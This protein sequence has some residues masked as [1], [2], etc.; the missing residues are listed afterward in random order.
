MRVS[1][2]QSPI[3]RIEGR[4]RVAVLAA[5]GESAGI[6]RRA[7]ITTMNQH[8]NNE[9]SRW[10]AKSDTTISHVCAVRQRN[11]SPCVSPA[12]KIWL[13][14]DDSARRTTAVVTVTKRPQHDRRW[15]KEL[16]DTLRT[17]LR[18]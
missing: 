7:A 9:G 4:S 16:T 14:V 5:E 12:A 18:K 1:A 6:A 13:V 15:D 3:D 17:R 10:L 11:R 8:F 2:P